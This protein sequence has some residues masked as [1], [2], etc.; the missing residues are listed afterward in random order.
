VKL[1]TPTPSQL[2]VSRNLP[3][4]PSMDFFL[5]NARRIFDVAKAVVPDAIEEFA[6]V[7]RP[8]G[9]LHFLM[10]SPF[11]L[12]AAAVYAGAHSAYKITRSGA[13]VR[14][15]GM[16]FGKNCV[17]EQRYARLRLLQDQALYR[18]AEPSSSTPASLPPGSASTGV[19][20]A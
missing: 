7:I 1:D 11:S 8:D 15:E 17:L 12:D 3:I 2:K 10:E 16:S 9:G 4:K 5:E 14:V 20:W 6:V 13:G 18:L 19:S